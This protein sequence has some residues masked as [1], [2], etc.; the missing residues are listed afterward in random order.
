MVIRFAAASAALACGLAACIDPDYQCRT[1]LD[2]D[3]GVAGR[4]EIDHRC[5]ALD[6]S[7]A[8][9]RRYNDH[10]G[11][12]SGQCFDDQVLPVD[13]CA[14]GQPP[15]TPIGCIADVCKALPACCA[16]GWSEACVQAAQ[17]QCGDLVC[18]TRIAI[19]ANKPGKTEL[20]DLRWDGTAWSAHLDARQGVLAWLAPAPGTGQPRLAGFAPGAFI[21]DDL[22]TGVAMNHNYLEATSVDFDRDGRATAVLAY[23]DAAGP[24]LEVRKLDDGSSRVVA[25]VAVPRLSWGDVDH[26]AFPDGIAAEGTTTR[27]HLLS[28]NEAD[29]HGRAIDDRVVANV[30][31]GSAG[32]GGNPPPIRSFDWLDLDGDH[33]LD[34]VAYG[35]SVDVHPGKG[36]AIGTGVLA[37]ID[38]DPPAT[39]GSCDATTQSEQAFAGAALPGASGSALVVASH[40]ARALY[41]AQLRGMPAIVTATPYAFP[42]ESCAASCAPILAVVARDLDGDHALDVIAIDADL[43]VYT[44]LARAGM[45]LQAA[46]AI[47][48]ATSGFLAV[49]TSVTGAPR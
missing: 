41:R 47:P 7:C 34:V 38:C 9:R 23:T 18:D 26:D 8:T 15:A 49:R 13:R 42:A 25:S 3:V 45:Q 5:T 32:T 1:D 39:S 19:T 16:T 11:P 48:T 37:R 36:E 46:I 21:V 17:I 14:A 6:A 35:F 10:S 24:H 4:C 12:R 20:W 27:Y 2:C 33:Q 44:A 43:H 22:T 31:G 40:P 29:D 28:N 30:T